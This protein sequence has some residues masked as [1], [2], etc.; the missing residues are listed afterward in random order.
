MLATIGILIGIYKIFTLF[1]MGGAMRKTAKTRQA[2]T[3]NPLARVFETYETNRNAD[4]ETLELKLDEQI[5][6]ESPRIE[7]FND[8]IKVFAAVAPLLGLLGTVIGMIRPLAWL[9][10]KR[11][12]CAGRWRKPSP[13]FHSR[14]R[15]PTWVL[16]IYKLS[17]I[18][19]VPC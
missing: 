17:S 2:G 4:I 14:R 12:P 13:S 6:R 9:L 3:G 15:N 16:Q 10:R 7:R 18:V 8:I 1:T 5:L 11:N 19:A